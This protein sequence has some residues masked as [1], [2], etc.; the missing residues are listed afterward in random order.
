MAKSVRSCIVLIVVVVVV[1][2]LSLDEA[3]GIIRGEEHP[4]SYELLLDN[5]VMPDWLDGYGSQG[6][7]ELNVSYNAEGRH[8]AITHNGIFLCQS[9][10]QG[11][12]QVAISLSSS[13]PSGK[14][15]LLTLLMVDPDAPTPENHT[16]RSLV[17]W[18]VTNI[19]SSPPLH[20]QEIWER[21]CE[22][23]PYHGPKIQSGLHRYYFL[24]FQQEDRIHVPFPKD[25]TDRAPFSIRN[26][27]KAYNLGY[28]IAGVLFLVK[29]NGSCSLLSTRVSSH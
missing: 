29:V 20:Q 15:P 21:G 26:F 6:R 12:P 23:F 10:T 2:E 3:V 14:W 27:T 16:R 22:V 7:A 18:M 24:L 11:R 28:P 25:N 19:P 17:H 4:L 5:S 9:Q 13:S 8:T 1:V